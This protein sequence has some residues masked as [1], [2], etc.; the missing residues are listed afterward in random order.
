[1]SSP[2]A[3]YR[4]DLQQRI[5]DPGTPDGAFVFELGQ[6]NRGDARFAIGDFHEVKQDFLRAPQS[7]FVAPIVNIIPC[8]DDGLYCEWEFSIRL[9]G[10]VMYTRKLETGIPQFALSDIR[11]PLALAVAPPATNELAFRLELTS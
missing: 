7:A 9:N 11:V 6:A 1:M 3:Q 10:V 2:F 5:L 8:D 4:G